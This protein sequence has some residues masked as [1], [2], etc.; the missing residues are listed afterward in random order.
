LKKKYYI[1]MF[2]FQK[3]EIKLETLKLME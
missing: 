2:F 3:K 1:D